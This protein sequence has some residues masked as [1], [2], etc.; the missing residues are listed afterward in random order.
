MGRGCT[1]LW[2]KVLLELA[3]S[4]F[5][6]TYILPVPYAVSPLFATLTKTAGVYL[7]HSQIGTPAFRLPW[8]LVDSATPH[9]LEAYLAVLLFHG[10]QITGH[11][12]P[13]QS[14]LGGSST[15]DSKLTT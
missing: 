13:R 4:L 10:T 7:L 6:L 15:Y 2:V 12:P 8:P 5:N 1:P 14:L 11:G 9:P 3:R